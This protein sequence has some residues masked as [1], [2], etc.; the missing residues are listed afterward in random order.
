MEMA[1]QPKLSLRLFEA[2]AAAQSAR[3][4]ASNLGSVIPMIRRGARVEEN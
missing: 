1:L 2:S 3:I 4:A